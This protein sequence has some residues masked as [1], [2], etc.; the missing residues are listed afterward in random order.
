MIRGGLEEKRKEE[1]KK[2]EESPLSHRSYR[3]RYKPWPLSK[4]YKSLKRSKAFDR[5]DRARI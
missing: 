4:L 5:P 1:W 2:R 3:L